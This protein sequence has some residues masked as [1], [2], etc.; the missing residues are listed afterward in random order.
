MYRGNDITTVH[1]YLY[2]I[3][4]VI[5]WR[6]SKLDPEMTSHKLATYSKWT[7]ALEASAY[8]TPVLFY[9]VQQ[10][11]ILRYKRMLKPG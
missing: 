11:D 8:P 9:F 7:I 6:L 5:A 1:W 4:L 10:S 2:G 3:C